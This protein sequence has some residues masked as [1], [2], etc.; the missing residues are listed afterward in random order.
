MEKTTLDVLGMTCLGCVRSVKGVLER[1]AGVQSVEV[2]L[3]DGTA[4]VSFDPTLT[5]IETLKSAIVDAGYDV[6]T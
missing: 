2:S 6:Q 4:T 1:V 5:R 3:K